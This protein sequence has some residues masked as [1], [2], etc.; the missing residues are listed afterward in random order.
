MKIS[1]KKWLIGLVLFIS[2]TTHVHA[3]DLRPLL[4]NLPG[5]KVLEKSAATGFSESYTV[6]FTVPVNHNDSTQGYF[7][8]RVFISHR[9]FDAP[10]VCVTEGYLASYANNAWY[11][12]E[13]AD[14][15]KANQIVIEHRFFG[16]S[17]PEGCPWEYLN[18]KQAAAD[19][20]Q[21]ITMLKTIYKGKWVTTGSSKGGSTAVYHHA[22]YPNDVDA[23]VAYVAPF[24]IADEDPRTID[25][26]KQVGPDSV[27]AKILNFQ[28]AV[29][30]NRTEVMRYFNIDI[31]NAKDTLVVSP[32]SA[33][34]YMVLEYPFSF[35][36]YC[37]NQAAI[38]SADASPKVLYKHLKS[39]VPADAYSAL[40]AGG[41][42]AFYTQ[43]YAEV[44]YYGYDSIGLGDLLIMKSAFISNKV[45]V[46][47]ATP[48]TYNPDA[49]IFVRD[50]IKHK[51]NN[52]I[53]IY[54]AD[55]PWSAA[56]AEP[57][58]ETNALKIVAP[59]DC[60]NVRIAG[61]PDDLRNQVYNRLREWL[62]VTLE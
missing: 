45:L 55:D 42:G 37:G 38:P 13:L 60:H 33:L 28:R 58:Q 14:L 44:G 7:Q 21:I 3:Q 61:L 17:M 12:E 62:G 50:F 53:Y 30:K 4:E 52:I 29:L 35:W 5:V 11:I 31:A 57:G 19:H 25:F 9:S 22:F 39:V 51:G 18:V 56:A 43:A 2:L 47:K 10:T 16:K 48:V 40:D 46:P 32:D 49:L 26:L 8:Q 54:G 34:D 1:N 6:Y 41:T 59:G 20:H 24:T 36:Q 15:L 27:R 23:T